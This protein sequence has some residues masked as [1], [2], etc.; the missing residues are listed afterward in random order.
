[1]KYSKLL[2]SYS[3]GLLVLTS[4][5]YSIVDKDKSDYLLEGQRL[6]YQGSD[7]QEVYDNYVEAY[8]SSSHDVKSRA[9]YGLAQ[10]AK[11]RK[12]FSEHIFYL[13]KAFEYGYTG[14]PVGL[15][16]AYLAHGDSPEKRAEAKKILNNEKHHS[17]EANLVLAEQAGQKGNVDLMK[18][19]MKQS[20]RLYAS[21]EDPEGN[22]ALKIARS[23]EGLI[24]GDAKAFDW[25]KIA[26]K[27]GHPEAALDF[28]RLLVKMSD[29]GS[30]FHRKGMAILMDEANKGN[31]KAI[32]DIAKITADNGQL[33]TSIAW[34]KKLEALGDR[35]GDIA[36]RIGRLYDRSTP[37]V[38]KDS[39]SEHWYHKAVAKNNNKAIAFLNKRKQQERDRLAKLVKQR[40]QKQ[41]EEAQSSGGIRG[42]KGRSLTATEAESLKDA[43]KQGGDEIFIKLAQEA[44]SIQAMMMLDSKKSVS[45][46][47]QYDS[48][49]RRAG[50][51]QLYSIVKKHERLLG[52]KSKQVNLQLE[53]AAHY[54]S[55]KAAFKRAK[56]YGSSNRKKSNKWYGKAA[57][58]GHT[59]S[60]LYLARNYS[61]EGKQKEA[62][63][64][65]EK[66]AKAGEVEGQYQAGVYY[67]RGQGVTKNIQEA[68]YW[69]NKAK[70]NGYEL[71]LHTLQ[72]IE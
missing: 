64:W 72:S 55:A 48:Y 69:L 70:D 53:L 67:A 13:E 3:L 43:Y 52:A 31:P 49:Y 36:Y 63:F 18:R 24:Y 1:M 5:E 58:L 20:E 47:Y 37:N 21:A 9:A 22:S 15:A 59:K 23:Y 39:N 10:I 33:L 29:Q 71:A 2:A 27:K 45:G 54:G 40:E 51:Q 65:Y 6:S 25:Y 41:L 19:Y 46:A 30:I 12:E 28:S 11:D 62:F 8:R 38:K 60:M 61:I 32:R 56:N 35:D 26:I 4:C 57:E 42:F 50:H 44:Q 16:K 34:H 66:A 14:S 68:K 17:L 7:E